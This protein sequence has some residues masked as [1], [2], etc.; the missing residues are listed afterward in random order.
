MCYNGRSIEIKP[1][2]SAMEIFYSVIMYVGIFIYALWLGVVAVISFI[3]SLLVP[4]LAIML[5]VVLVRMLRHKP[6]RDV[7]YLD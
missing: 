3:G 1:R 6:K 4:I 2:G 5:I 7:D